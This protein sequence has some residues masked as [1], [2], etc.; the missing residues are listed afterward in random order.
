MIAGSKCDMPLKS[1][2]AIDAA[3]KHNALMVEY[4]KARAAL[5]KGTA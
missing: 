2:A 3:I 1:Q 5:G 4:R